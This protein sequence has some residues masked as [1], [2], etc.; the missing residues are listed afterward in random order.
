MSGVIR[1]WSG[2]WRGGMRRR[3]RWRGGWGGGRITFS[4]G[5]EIRRRDGWEGDR[6]GWRPGA[7]RNREREPEKWDICGRKNRRVMMIEASTFKHTYINDKAATHF[8]Y[9]VDGFLSVCRAGYRFGEDA[10]PSS[11]SI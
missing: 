11:G 10:T 2:S 1:R 3:G 4:G 8:R 9:S 6:E 5:R 7:G